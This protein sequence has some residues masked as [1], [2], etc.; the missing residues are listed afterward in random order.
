SAGAIGWTQFMPATWTRYGVDANGDGR[1]DP[2]TAA[3]AI[4]AAARYLQASGAPGDWYGALFAYNHAD[5]YVAEVLARADQ[6]AAGQPLTSEPAASCSSIVDIG[7]SRVRRV[8]SG[9][10]LVSVPGFP[11]QRVDARILPDIK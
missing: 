7:I 8:T 11:D 3:D 5:W 9:G 10:G 2:Y 1:R 6:F 4:F